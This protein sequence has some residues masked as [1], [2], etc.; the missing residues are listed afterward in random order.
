MATWS[1]DRILKTNLQLNWPIEDTPLV[2]TFLMYFF[3]MVC[4][5]RDFQEGKRPLRHLV[6][7]CLA[8]GDRIFATGSDGVSKSVLRFCGCF[9]L[10]SGHVIIHKSFFCQVHVNELQFWEFSGKFRRCVAHWPQ[11][12]IVYASVCYN[13]GLAICPN[14][15]A[16]SM[17]LFG[18]DPQDDR[19]GSSHRVV[20]KNVRRK[21]TALLYTV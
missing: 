20:A 4:F 14:T 16:S 17:V 2:K 15:S 1:R 7:A 18:N 5:P 9:C 19:G 21:T 12:H 10:I 8:T 6:G 13:I 3:L 11:L